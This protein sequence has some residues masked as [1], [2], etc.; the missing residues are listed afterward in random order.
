MMTMLLLDVTTFITDGNKSV[1]EYNYFSLNNVICP[2][3][4]TVTIRVPFGDVIIRDFRSNLRWRVRKIYLE[5]VIL[6]DTRTA[7]KPV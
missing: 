6:S 1:F 4:A 3:R 5:I 7:Q 2:L